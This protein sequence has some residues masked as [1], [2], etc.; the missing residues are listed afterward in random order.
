MG[1]REFAL[2]APPDALSSREAGIVTRFVVGALLVSH[3]ARRDVRVT[4]YFGE[5]GAV[6]LD[7]ASMR[8]V[9]PDEQ[10]LSGILKAGLRKVRDQG[11]GR[12]MQGIHA[13]D[14][15]FFDAI[16]AQKGSRVFYKSAG[17]RAV[18]LDGDF[19]AA[20]EHPALQ[21]RTE[22]ALSKAGFCAINLG[23]ALMPVDQAAVVINNRVDR[24][25]GFQG[26][27]F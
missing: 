2:L 7:G 3:G 1:L 25:P 17:G 16:K 8:N 6:S 23:G 10:S 19:Y 12:V 5:A 26:Y 11:R 13:G 20:F 14:A 9:R 22:E 4:V 18:S 24:Q 21:P 15:D 27:T